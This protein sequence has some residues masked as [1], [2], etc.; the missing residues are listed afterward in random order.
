MAHWRESSF[1]PRRSGIACLR[2]R[3]SAD[4]QNLPGRSVGI[5]AGFAGFGILRRR[6]HP[7]TSHSRNPST[8]GRS[9]TPRGR[10]GYRNSIARFLS[11]F[12]PS[13]LK[14]SHVA[15]YRATN[16]FASFPSEFRTWCPQCRR[17]QFLHAKTKWLSSRPAR[18]LFIKSRLR[19]D[20]RFSF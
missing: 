17:L 5:C 16:G 18:L 19:G 12:K 10:R 20:Q 13:E 4:R 1:D 7:R 3:T 15:V 8:A 14:A 11:V 6:R 9:R 2:P